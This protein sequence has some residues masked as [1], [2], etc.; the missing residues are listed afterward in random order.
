M[1]L[2][3]ERKGGA[4]GSGWRRS[5]LPGVL[6]TRRQAPLSLIACCDPDSTA[7]RCGAAQQAPLRLSDTCRKACRALGAVQG[8]WRRNSECPGCGRSLRLADGGPPRH[9]HAQGSRDTCWRCWTDPAANP[10]CCRRIHQPS[11]L[12][13]RRRGAELG[14]QRRRATLG[15]SGRVAATAGCTTPLTD[16]EQRP[17]C[18]RLAD[19]RH[20]H[21]LRSRR[22][23]AFLRNLAMV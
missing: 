16:A 13:R 22:P 21:L 8:K 23:G 17:R 11:R 20:P 18:E 3:E 2:V 12:A 4:R 7:A 14:G 1:R 9:A 10:G 15:A 6:G 5:I 19:G